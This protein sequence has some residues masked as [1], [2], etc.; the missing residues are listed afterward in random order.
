M[1]F[2][3]EYVLAKEAQ[4][5]DRIFILSKIEAKYG[6]EKRREIEEELLQKGA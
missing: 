1:S 2:W 5:F 6:A 3:A 4:G